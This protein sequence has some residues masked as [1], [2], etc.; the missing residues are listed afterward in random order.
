MKRISL[1]LT[2]LAPALL[3]GCTVKISKPMVLEREDIST[4]SNT[5]DLQM[6]FMKE[7]GNENLYCGSRQSDVADVRS[8]G[9]SLGAST[10][11]EVGNLGEGSSEGALSLGGR[12]PSVLI[13]REMLYRA[14]ELSMNLNADAKTTIEIY[15]KFLDSIEK[16]TQTQTG[17][18][19]A[20]V[21]QKANTEV[22]MTENG[23][24]ALA[25]PAVG[26]ESDDSDSDDYDGY[27]SDDN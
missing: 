2:F 25:S 21:G 23:T 6:T 18:G 27:N 26:G 15:S 19:A 5:S 12:S 24:A 13:V 9:A 7:H 16:I 10:L 4:I 22:S 11:G 17:A 14:C 1:V 20:A 8:V 3:L